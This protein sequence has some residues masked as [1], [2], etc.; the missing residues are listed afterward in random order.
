MASKKYIIQPEIYRIN[1]DVWAEGNS[2]GFK[3]KGTGIAYINNYP[4]APT[5]FVSFGGN[6]GEIDITKW[7][8]VFA[9]GAVTNEVWVFR[10][11]YA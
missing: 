1:T 11:K 5:E 6:E 7:K 3:N 10:K 9:P 4:L 2:I 8:I